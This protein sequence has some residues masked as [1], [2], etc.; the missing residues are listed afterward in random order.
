MELLGYWKII[1]KRLWFIVPMIVL[2]VAGAA[3]YSEQQVPVYSTSTTLFLNPRSNSSMPSYLSVAYAQSL[4]DTYSAFMRTRSFAGLV[5]EETEIPMSAGEILGSLSSSLVP[6]TQ[7]FKI[8]AVHPDPHKAQV[9][10]NTAANVLIDQNIARQQAE[11]Q[12]IAAQDNPARQ[13][14]QQR[15]TELQQSLQDELT[16]YG[17]R[18]AALQA[19]IAGLESKPPSAETDQRILALRQELV[20]Y[21]SLR[22]DIFGSLVQTQ[23]ALASSTGSSDAMADTAVVIDPAPL[24]L[25]PLPR[26]GL[27]YILMALAVSLG[28]GIGLAFLIEYLDWTIKTPEELDAVYGLSTLGVIGAIRNG[29]RNRTGQEGL[30]TLAAPHSPIAEAFRALRTNIQFASPD[31]P[32]GS[33]MVTSAG[34]V[35]GKT[36]ISANLAIVLAQAGKRVIL[37]DTDLRRPRVHKL[38]DLSRTSGFTDLVI[39]QENGVEAYL[40]PTAVDNLRVLACGPLPV[41]PAELLGSPRVGQVMEQLK[42]HADVVVYDTPPAATVTDAVVLG[43]RVDAVIQVV[44][45]GGPRRDVVRRTKGLLEKVGARVLGPVLNGVSLSD[46]GYYNYYYYGYYHE[47]E[48]SSRR[49]PLR[50]LWRR[51]RGDRRG[52]RPKKPPEEQAQS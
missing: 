16:Y 9:V 47:G 13:L 38:F 41:N 22:T 49:S 21:Q 45:A 42:E 46:V 7:F 40:Q 20:N 31:K 29:S 34:P 37:V 17:D 12:Q 35:E 33:L 50:R 15:L 26:Q 27:R 25:A 52:H 10:A 18:I 43:S 19:Q 32:V 44:R 39:D 11:K 4:A 2:A 30:V 48:R 24:P 5:A 36:L 6:E 1:R 14:E 28:V 23:S 3:Y 8:Q 51:L